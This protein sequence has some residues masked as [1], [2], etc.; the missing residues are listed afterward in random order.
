MKFTDNTIVLL[1]N[2]SAI[3]TNL[4]F[5]TGNVLKTISP[6]KNILA[7]TKVEEHFPQDFAIYDLNKF[8][9]AISLLINQK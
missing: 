1:K 6:Q 7:R 8:L 4:Q 2:F 5:T 9:G 3:N